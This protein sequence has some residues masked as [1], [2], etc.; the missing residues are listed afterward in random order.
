MKHILFILHE[1]YPC[2]SA[3]TNCLKAIIEEMQH[4]NIKVDIITRKDEASLLDYEIINNVGVYRINDYFNIFLKEKQ[5]SIGIKKF[6]YRVLLKFILIYRNKFQKNKQG[7]FNIK[8]AIKLSSKNMKKNNYDCVITCSFPF[9]LHYVGNALKQKYNI[10]WFAYEFDPHTYNFT[11]DQRFVEERKREE[12]SIL[13]LADKVFLTQEIV[14]YNLKN[15]FNELK[16]KY[17]VIPYAL[18]KKQNIEIKNNSS[19]KITFVYAG[20]FYK[21]IRVPDKMLDALLQL[22]FDFEIKL[23]YRCDLEIKEKLTNYQNKFGGKLLLC[24]DATKEECDLAMANANF[25][26]NIGNDI[27]N[28]TPSKVYEL[29]TFGKP[30]INFY[31]LPEDTSKSILENYPLVMNI[32]KI[33]NIAIKELK[34]FCIENKDK[35]LDFETSTKKYKKAEV[36]AKEFIHRI[37]EICNEK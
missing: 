27:I 26:L 13:S 15:G 12:I 7:Y 20:N 31:N 1:Y 37:G 36:V 18:I 14:D 23:F 8:K 6:I 21:Q 22:D 17:E 29:I 19:D 30:I 3:I 9:E 35:V 16:D 5:K 24:A 10:K 32:C 33:D 4:Q 34:D 11:F 25:I 2:G 28:Q